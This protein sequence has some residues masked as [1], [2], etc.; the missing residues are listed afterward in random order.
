MP[1][2]INVAHGFVFRVVHNSLRYNNSN[3]TQ[4]TC[5]IDSNKTFETGKYYIGNMKLLQP[6]K[7]LAM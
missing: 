5:L 7:S 2:L 4:S 3:I 1:A 6:R